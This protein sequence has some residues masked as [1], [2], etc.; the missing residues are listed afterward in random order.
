[1]S[2]GFI[3]DIR[4]G[5]VTSLFKIKSDGIS[6]HVIRDRINVKNSL[7]CFKLSLS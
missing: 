6:S 2:E 4:R 5:N 7:L 3:Y 1:M